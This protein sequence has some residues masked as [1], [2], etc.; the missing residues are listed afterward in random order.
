M[1]SRAPQTLPLSLEQTLDEDILRVCSDKG[2]VRVI[3]FG[4]LNL[5]TS[6]APRPKNLIFWD[7]A[8]AFQGIELDS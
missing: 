3:R 5:T 6:H 1:L 4:R 2:G 7:R 8:S